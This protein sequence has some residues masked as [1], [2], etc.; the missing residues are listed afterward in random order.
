MSELSKRLQKIPPYLFV[1]LDRLKNEK[2]KEGA[3]VIDL[4]IGDPDIPTPQEIVDV[5]KR[6]LEKSE[7]HRYPA[8]PEVF[9]SQGLC[10]LYAK[11]LWSNL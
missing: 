1:E 4:G 11:T 8:N 10:R 6:A 5:A 7:Y 3:D 9:F 2:I